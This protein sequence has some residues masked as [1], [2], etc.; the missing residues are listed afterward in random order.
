MYLYSIPATSQTYNVN[1][2]LQSIFFLGMI[3]GE[4]NRWSL[5]TLVVPRRF[6]IRSTDSSLHLVLRVPSAAWCNADAAQPADDVDSTRQAACCTRLHS[7]TIFAQHNDF[8]RSF[9]FNF[10]INK[11]RSRKKINGGERNV[12]NPSCSFPIYVHE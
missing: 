4:N 7:T 9:F 10:L 1:E 5:S 6:F 11:G 8:L 3:G 2:R 12:E